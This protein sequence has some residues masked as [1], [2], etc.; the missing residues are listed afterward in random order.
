MKRWRRSTDVG[1]TIFWSFVTT[2]LLAK[3]LPPS[4]ADGWLPAILGSIAGLIG[5]VVA[6]RGRA[7][8]RREADGE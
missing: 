8:E 6:L 4:L 2:A 1:Y 5:A 7:R 3:L